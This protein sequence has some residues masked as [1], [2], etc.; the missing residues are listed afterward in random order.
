MNSKKFLS[1]FIISVVIIV[2]LV[3]VGDLGNLIH[4]T[5]NQ[6]QAEDFGL[7]R[8]CNPSTA[9]C[10]VTGFLKGN[11]IRVS[12]NIDEP[13]RMGKKFPVNLFISGI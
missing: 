9:V 2:V 10:S 4:Q 1:I 13:I 8:N 5:T 11:K 7:V 12:M 3:T 6:N